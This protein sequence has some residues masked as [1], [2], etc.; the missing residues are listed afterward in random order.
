MDRYDMDDRWNDVQ[1]WFFRRLW[2]PIFRHRWKRRISGYVCRRC[3][4]FTAYLRD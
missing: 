1:Q 2:C 4:L 3:N